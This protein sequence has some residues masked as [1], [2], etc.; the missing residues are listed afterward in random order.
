MAIVITTMLDGTA[1]GKA[2]DNMSAA[3]TSKG[4]AATAAAGSLQKLIDAAPTGSTIQL[5]AGSYA[6]SIVISKPLRVE[7][8][9]VTLTGN[10]SDAPVATI[11]AKGASL[12]GLTAEKDTRGKAPAVL[13]A[14]DNVVLDGLKVLSRSLGIQLQ[15]S[16]GSTIR[17]SVVEP[18]AD[19]LG[20]AARASD[21]RNGIDLYRSNGNLIEDNR[22]SSM[23]DGIYLEGSNNNT[24]RGNQIDYS[25]YG[26]HLMYTKRSVVT[27]NSGSYNVTGIMAMMVKGSEL[28]GNAFSR[29]SGSVNSQGMLFYQVESTRVEDNVMNGNRVGMYIERS[30]GNEWINN[31]I[32]YNFV[33]I[34]LLDSKD[35]RL[36]NNRFVS[37]VIET[38]ADGSRDNELQGN[39]WDAFE[40]LDPN[41]DGSSDLA[42]LMNPF[43]QRLTKDNSAYQIFFQ[44]P[45]MKFLES[46]LAS[47]QQNW[48]RD[49]APLMEPP[50]EIGSKSQPTETPM[51]ATAAAGVALLAGALIIIYTGVRRK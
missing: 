30:E 41:G 33:G 13:V 36:K 15:S 48:S 34:Q 24:V 12:I 3:A 17:G 18:P 8:Q 43:F 21:S 19:L 26:I 28:T 50:L 51:A 14:A 20:R 35:N 46:L 1:S 25:R 11:K 49:S 37:N 44:S 39:Y 23:F 42:Y 27:D 2:A 38:Q 4:T 32:S 7:A 31:D 5:P 29:Q 10:G 47:G 9:D 40:G 45:G 22:V 16:Q 6:Q